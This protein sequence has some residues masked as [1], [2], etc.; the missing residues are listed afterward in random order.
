MGGFDLRIEFRTRVLGQAG[1]LVLESESGLFSANCAAE[2]GGRVEQG[3]STARIWLIRPIFRASTRRRC[4]PVSRKVASDLFA[5]LAQKKSR[6]DGG[7]ESNPDLSVA[8]L[9]FRYGE[10]KIA[11]QG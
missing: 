2:F 6:D 4:G 11:K 10:R 3:L 5:D 9:G 8:K 7:Y 1:R